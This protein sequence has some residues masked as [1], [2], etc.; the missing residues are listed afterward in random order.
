MKTKIAGLACGILLAGASLAHAEHR[1]LVTDLLDYKQFE[2]QT[3]Y[4]YSVL[5]PSF[6]GGGS[7]RKIDYAAVT[8][9]GAGLG[10][11]LELDLSLRQVFQERDLEPSG[12]ETRSGMGDFSATLDYRLPVAEASPLALVTGLGLKFDSAPQGSAGSGSTDL[13]PFLAASYR[14]GMGHLPY[15][16]Y[17]AILRNNGGA[18]SHEVTVGLEKE[19]NRFA[20]LDLKLIGSFDTATAERTSAEDFSYQAGAYLQLAKNFYLLPSLAGLQQSRRTIGEVHQQSVAGIKAALALYY[21]L[22]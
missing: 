8:T 1:L 9:A 16:E 17:R 15:A 21:Y 4:E 2:L 6:F 5:Q 3:G 12:V 20:T 18:D 14:L 22:E 7:Y 10:H 19:V 11:G 13:S